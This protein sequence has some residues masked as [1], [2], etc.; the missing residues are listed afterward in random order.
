MVKNSKLFQQQQKGQTHLSF[1]LLF[2][3]RS[4]AMLMIFWGASYFTMS[5][6]AQFCQNTITSAKTLDSSIDVGQGISIGPDKFSKKNKH[7]ALNKYLHIKKKSALP[8]FNKAVGPGKKSKMI[9]VEPTFI[10]ESKV[11]VIF[12]E[13]VNSC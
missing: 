2:K 4:C 13:Q 1:I 7:M 3:R 9:N 8:L 5:E 10:P 12:R 6:I 11:R